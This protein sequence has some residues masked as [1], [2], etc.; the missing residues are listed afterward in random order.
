MLKKKK[1]NYP[2]TKTIKK[3]TLHTLLFPRENTGKANYY[4][5]SLLLLFKWYIKY[6]SDH[7][8]E[9]KKKKLQ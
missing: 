5:K 7:L 2:H 1:K 9:T 8:Q 3:E 4:E 6:S